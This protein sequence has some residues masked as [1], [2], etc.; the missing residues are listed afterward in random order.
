MRLYDWKKAERILENG[1][2]IIAPT[3]TLYGVLARASDKKAVQKVYRIKG[4]NEKKPCI[5]LIASFADLKKFGISLTQSQKEFL[6]ELWPG[7]VSIVLPDLLKKFDYLHRGTETI[8]FRMI[9]KRSRNLYSLI[10]RVGPLVAPS[11]NPEGQAPACTMH[12]A[13]KYFG[14]AV[15]AY[16]CGGTRKSKP[17]TL[18]A[19]KNNKWVVLRKGAVKI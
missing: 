19:Y 12:E 18:I 5:V 2:V 3:D 6:Q 1:G 15:D 8:A 4:R 9:S 16:I 13:R 17:S 10:S 7:K 14:D 11:A